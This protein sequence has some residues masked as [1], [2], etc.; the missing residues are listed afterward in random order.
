MRVLATI[1]FT[2]IF[3]LSFGQSF[4]YPTIKRSASTANEFLPNGWTILKTASG[5]LNNDRI[6]DMVVVLQHKDSVTF[7]KHDPDFNPN[8]NDILT[9]QPRILIIA[10]Y[11]STIKSYKRIEQSNSFILCHDNPN[12]EEPFESITI[13]NGILKIHFFFF[14]N[15]G[16]WGMSNNYYMFRYQEDEFKLI[17]ADYN[18]LNRGSGETEDRSYNFLTKKVKIVIGNSSSDKQKTLW[19]TFDSKELKTFKTFAEPLSYEVE[20]DFYL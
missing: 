5:D 2:S 19:R 10:F 8:Y 1:L 11:D 16:G 18:Y 13:S 20:K 9:Y 3:G 14:M 15:C 7:I 12:A 17:G 6:A 4:T